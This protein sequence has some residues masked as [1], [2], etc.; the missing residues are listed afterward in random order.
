IRY[1]GDHGRPGQVGAGIGGFDMLRL[2]QAAGSQTSDTLALGATNGSGR[3]TI[4]GPGGTQTVDFE[5]LEPVVDVV[6]SPSFTITS[7]PA[8]ASLLQGPNVITYLASPLLAGGGRV[9]VDAFEPIDLLNKS[10]LTIN[11]GD[12]ADSVNLIATSTP[13]GLTGITIN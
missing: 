4:V 9:T 13:A 2:N 11:A 7:D 1:D 10:V 6:A 3:S 12:G 5:N 8:L